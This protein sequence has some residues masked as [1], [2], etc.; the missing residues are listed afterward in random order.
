MEQSDLEESLAKRSRDLAACTDEF[1]KTIV[2]LRERG[3]KDVETIWNAACH[4]NVVNHD[5]SAFLYFCTTTD[6]EWVRRAAARALATMLY[7]AIEDLPALFGKSFIKA[8][9]K[10]GVYREIE[11]DFKSAKKRLSTFSKCHCQ[12]L[13]HVR[14]NAGGHKDH[15]AVVFITAVV[16]A[17]TSK[18]I[19]LACEFNEILIE[20]GRFSSAVIDA[21]NA[22]YRRK[23]VIS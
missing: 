9:E 1:L 17:D 12:F 13:K 2:A 16:Q 20:L 3:Q 23:G 15:D 8:C 14:M 22:E 7:E 5:I 21:V 18:I 6:D 4:V 10:A 11:A 19:D